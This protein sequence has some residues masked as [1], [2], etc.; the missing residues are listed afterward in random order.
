MVNIS[1]LC[2]FIYFKYYQKTHNVY[3]IFKYTLSYEQPVTVC[4][5]FTT[6]NQLIWVIR[7]GIRLHRF[8]LNFFDSL[9]GPPHQSNLFRNYSM[10]AAYASR[11]ATHLNSMTVSHPVYCDTFIW[12]IFEGSI[13][14]SF[15]AYDIPQSCAFYFMRVELKNKNGIYKL[16]YFD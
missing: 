15:T 2:I 10:Q 11:K 9:K 4:I 6:K 3:S 13:N 8:A 5:W 1:F 7:S 14:I 12:L 16:R